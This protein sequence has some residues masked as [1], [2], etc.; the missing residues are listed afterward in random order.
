MYWADWLIDIDTDIDIDIDIYIYKA[1]WFDWLLADWV[2][3]IVWLS[4]WLIDWLIDTHCDA[5][6]FWIWFMNE[7]W[8]GMASGE[9]RVWVSISI[10]SG[11]SAIEFDK[12]IH[13]KI[14]VSI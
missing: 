10:L 2:W 1:D 14:E 7:K 12:Y 3:L 8:F 4:D 5:Y 13:T 9:F 6:I 11:D